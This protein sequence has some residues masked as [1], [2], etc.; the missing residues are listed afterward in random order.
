MS[1]K[2]VFMS[3]TA[4]AV[5]ASAFVGAEKAEAASHKVKSGDTLWSLSQKYETNV[6][7]LKKWNNLSNDSIFVNQ[8]LEVGNGGKSQA[9]NN[10][11]TNSSTSTV[12]QQTYTV[13]GGDTLSAIASRHG[14]SLNNL[15][16][17]NNLKSSLIYPGDKLVVKK[18]SVTTTDKPSNST[19]TNNK[20]SAP[21]NSGA[22]SGSSTYTVKSGDTLSGIASKHGISLNNLMNWNNLKSSLIYPGDKLV[23][24]NGSAADKPNN[25]TSTNNKPSTP[26]NS[27]TTTST[28]TVKSGDT[29]SGIAFKYGVSINNLM[30]WNNLNSTLIFPGNKLVIQG[31]TVTEKPNNSSGNNNTSTTPSNEKGNSSGSVSTSKLIDAAKSV[32]GTPYVWA[33][34]TPSGFDCS[35]YIYWAFN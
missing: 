6:A 4:S 22:T 16:A 9:S 3:V 28:Y 8:V 27:G 7:Q 35:G 19:S 11:Q 1:R 12:S 32:I 31:G 25:S 18:G 21:S 5:I 33:G 15:M 24:K 13:K 23:V 20:P 2:K 14:I 30:A 34:N 17:W 29:L 26:A 10:K